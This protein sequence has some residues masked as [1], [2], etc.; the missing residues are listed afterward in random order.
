MK[1]NLLDM[2]VVAIPLLR[3]YLLSRRGALR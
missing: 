1:P 3:N 2:P